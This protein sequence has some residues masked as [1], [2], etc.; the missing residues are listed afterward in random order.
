MLNIK[1]LLLIT[2]NRHL[3]L[4]ILVLFYVWEDA[5]VSFDVHL[6]SSKPISCFSPPQSTLLGFGEDWKIGY[7]G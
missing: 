5:R 1:Q 7:S 2:K 3:K 6:D 4:M